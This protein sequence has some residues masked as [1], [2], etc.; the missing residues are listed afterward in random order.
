[1]STLDQGLQERRLEVD[2][3]EVRLLEQGSGRPV[4]LIHGLG[5]SA[6]VWEPHLRRLAKAG[7]RGLAPDLPGFG[8]SGGPL[9][10]LSVNTA[11]E[12]LRRLADVLELEEAAWLGHSIGTQQVVRLAASAPGRA[13]ALILVA[14]TGRSGRHALRP[15][16]GLVATA[17]QEQPRLVAGVVRRYLRSPTT[18]LGTWVR[19]LRHDTALDAPLVACPAL[20]VLGE[21]DAVVPESFAA[22]LERVLPDPAMARIDG[23]THAVALDPVHPFM[24]AVLRFLTRRYP[25]VRS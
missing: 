10:G 20:I 13:A 24:D 14:P 17:V 25:P 22:L 3:R 16:G 21:R 2:G 19:S 11:A 15:V 4:V 5:L 8:E 6:T 9:T 7:Y 18:T 12:W 1:M 23:A